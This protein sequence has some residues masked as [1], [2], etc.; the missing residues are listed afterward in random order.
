MQTIY[1]CPFD[2]NRLTGTPIRA[3]TTIEEMLKRY[4]VGVISLGDFSKNNIKLNNIWKF[5]KQGEPK[6]RVLTYT[7]KVLYQLIKERPLVIHS[8]TSIPIIAVLLY[9]TLFKRE[10]KLIF[11]M[12]GVAKFECKNASLGWRLL[13]ILFDKLALRYAD[14]IISMSYSQK[15]FLI[16]V[17]RV[18]DKKIEVLW[19][20][21]DFHLFPYREPNREER[22]IVGYSGNDSYY[23]GIDTIIKAAEILKDD[24]SIEFI[25]MGVEEEKY[26][27]L[28]LRNVKFLGVADFKKIKISEKLAEC[29]VLLSPRISNKVTHLQYPYKLSFYLAV[30]RPVI[31]TDVSDQAL[32]IRQANCGVVVKPDAPQVLAKEILRFKTLDYKERRKMGENARKFAEGFLSVQRLGNKLEDIYKSLITVSIIKPKGQKLQKLVKYADV[33]DRKYSM[34]EDPDILYQIERISQGHMCISIIQVIEKYLSSQDKVLE[35]GCG[36]GRIIISLMKRNKISG[37]GV[38]FSEKSIRLAKKLAYHSKTPLEIIK[39]DLINLPFPDNFFD[40]VFGDS[41]L[42]HILDYERVLKEITRVTKDNG[43]VIISVPNKFRPDGWDLYKYLKKISYPQLS[44]TILRLKNLFIRNRLK[45]IES[46]GDGVILK[47]NFPLILDRLIRNDR[48]CKNKNL[49]SYYS[50]LIIPY[51]KK[52]IPAWA[53]IDIGV[54][55]KKSIL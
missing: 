11:E 40:V 52:F 55:G 28:R 42:E 48:G 45:V 8:F 3:K 24:N 36:T 34:A 16:N 7:I 41:V 26:S 54:V 20:P 39:A 1:L 30:G 33:W 21:V 25:I 17:Y 6:F 46:F 43:K 38:D 31:C 22:F 23:Q 9:K 15:D 19:G 29:S 35:V 51:I 12:H 44:F 14:K 13:N 49:D 5:S 18:T 37:Y 10:C 50:N 53:C 27:N 2:L 32:I 47:R 4:D